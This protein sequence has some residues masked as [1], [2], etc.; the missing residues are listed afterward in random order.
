MAYI[1]WPL[2]GV[3]VAFL[4]GAAPA[5]HAYHATTGA[6]LLAG[7]FGALIGGILGDGIAA[8]ID[9]AISLPSVAGALLGAAIFVWAIRRAPPH[10]ERPR[11]LRGEP[12]ARKE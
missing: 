12:P 2:I 8:A 10:E 6:S 5:R 3:L 1:I 9:G 7:A 11:S 4:F